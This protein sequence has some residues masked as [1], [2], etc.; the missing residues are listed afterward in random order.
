MGGTWDP[1]NPWGWFTLPLGIFQ[2]YCIV[3]L[4][5]YM[6]ESAVAQHHVCERLLGRKVCERIL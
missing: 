3:R 6:W 5:V 4:T 1:L 2:M